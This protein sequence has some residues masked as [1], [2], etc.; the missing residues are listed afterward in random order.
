MTV[1]YIRGKHDYRK[2]CSSHWGTAAL[3]E[4]DLHPNQLAVCVQ[5]WPCCGY[6]IFVNKDKDS[7]AE[8]TPILSVS[9]AILREDLT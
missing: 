7:S 4:V 3:V 9:H 8:R 6:E 2:L 1:S 5:F